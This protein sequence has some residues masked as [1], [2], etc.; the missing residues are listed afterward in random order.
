MNSLFA[1]SNRTVACLFGKAL[2][3]APERGQQLLSHEYRKDHAASACASCGR[4]GCRVPIVV[5]IFIQE[6]CL[7]RVASDCAIGDRR[8]SHASCQPE[9]SRLRLRLLI[10]HVV[11]RAEGPAICPVCG[12][13]R[14]YDDLALDL[15][16][17]HGREGRGCICTPVFAL[18]IGRSKM[19][20]HGRCIDMFCQHG[21]PD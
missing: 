11:G 16:V 3:R 10:P 6:G 1:L 14:R 2:G 18:Q 20:K 5:L 12:G 13:G 15:S 9:A 19:C 17:C 8:D 7:V 21:M 4:C